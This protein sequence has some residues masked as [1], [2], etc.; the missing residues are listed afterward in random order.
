LI[1]CG[2]HVLFDFVC[3][4]SREMTDSPLRFNSAGKGV[5][6]LSHVAGRTEVTRAFAES[7]LRLLVPR[8]RGIPAWVYLS[9]YGGGMVAGD[10]IDLRV[11]I[12]A[13]AVGVLG[14][15]ASTK[16]YRSPSQ[17]PC[18]QTLRA[19]VADA[20]LLVLAPDPLT[21]F[22]QACYEQSHSIRLEESGSLVLVDW[23]TSG[24]RARGESWA[25]SRYRSRLQVRRN[26]ELILA[27]GLLLDP[28]DGPL[29]SPFRLG[30]FHCLAMIA[31][32]G[33]QL[34]TAAEDLLG[35]IAAKPVPA[36]AGLLD[37]ASPIPHGIVVRVMGETTESV[38]RYVSQALSFLDKFLDEGPWSRKW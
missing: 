27:D 14:T 31:L 38:S 12:G 16:V 1:D 11:R 8:R 24:R 6:E 37:A 5:L 30:R 26:D 15:Q 2:E 29:D 33:E 10:E 22:A 32:I 18:R 36:R 7:P 4:D 21:C 3:D 13:R 35:R 20:G 19:T 23:L 28:I 25:F 9:T 17:V 34:A